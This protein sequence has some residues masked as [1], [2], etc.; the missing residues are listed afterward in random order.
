MLSNP[1]PI[2]GLDRGFRTSPGPVHCLCST[3]GRPPSHRKPIGGVRRSKGCPLA[4]RERGGRRGALR[5]Q[6]DRTILTR[7]PH[8]EVTRAV[9][10]L[11][12][13]R[14]SRALTQG[15]RNAGCRAIGLR[16]IL[17][18]SEIVAPGTCTS[19]MSLRSVLKPKDIGRG[20]ELG[21]WEPPIFTFPGPDWSCSHPFFNGH[22]IFLWTTL[23]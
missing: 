18:C 7:L 20:Q 1:Y 6:N 15:P 23:T 14:T 13:V 3:I 19:R 9:V 16:G 11:P 17:S 2:A 12:G 8:S 10:G 4:S 22:C 5:A 21:L